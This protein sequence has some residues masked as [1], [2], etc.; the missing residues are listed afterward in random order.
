MLQL[1]LA[2]DAL[3]E[4]LAFWVHYNDPQAKRELLERYEALPARQRAALEQA[5]ERVFPGPTLTAYRRTKPGDPPGKGGMSVSTDRPTYMA[6]FETFE[7]RPEDVLLH[8]AVTYPNGDTTALGSK[9]FGHEHEIILRPSAR[10]RRVGGEVREQA[11]E[12]VEITGYH[13]SDTLFDHFDLAHSS[14]TAVWGPGLY[15]SAKKS[16]LSGW[17]KRPGATGYLYEVLVTTSPDRVVDMTKPLPSEVY[18][19]IEQALGRAL[20]ASTKDDGIFPFMTLERRY[21][22]VADALRAIGFDVLIHEL[23]DAHGKHYLV[24]RPEA[25]RIVSVQSNGEVRVAEG[26][27]QSSYFRGGHRATLAGPFS[28]AGLA[29]AKRIGGKIVETTESLPVE[30]D[31]DY[32][33]IPAYARDFERARVPVSQI[34][35]PFINPISQERIDELAQLEDSGHTLPPI[36]VDGPHEVEEVDYPEEKYPF[37]DG[38]YPEVGEEFWYVHD[39]HHRVALAIE[40]GARYIDALVMG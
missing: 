14:P 13:F 35:S 19:Q 9:G 8:W 36:I 6:A 4:P 1:S 39:G 24:V 11:D 30:W 2:L 40:R 33:S 17:S 34:A 12:I 21:G 29:F 7:L 32:G 18:A 28:D 23:S 38:H 22:T 10:P 5:V 3:H 26:I 15:L 37:L 20:P 31:E 27:P 16:G 25:G